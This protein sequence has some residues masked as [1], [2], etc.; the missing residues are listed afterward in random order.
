ME[1]S[2]KPSKPSLN[3]GTIVYAPF[4]FFEA[5]MVCLR[6]SFS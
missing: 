6:A 1:K 3:S 5:L 4:Q 2:L